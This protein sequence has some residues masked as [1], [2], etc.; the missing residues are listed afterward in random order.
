MI[1]K[2]KYG[3]DFEGMKYGWD[4][5]ILFRLP[6]TIG[7]NY[8]PLKKL[9]LIKVGCQMGYLLNRKR[10]SLPQLKSMTIYINFELQI[11]E[12]ENLPF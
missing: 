1:L 6:Q 7:K 3:I 9:T 2:Y 4:K 8:Y 5:G 12:D 10:K 11:I